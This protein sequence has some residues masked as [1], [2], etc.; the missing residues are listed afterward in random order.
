M[1]YRNLASVELPPSYFIEPTHDEIRPKIDLFL[2]KSKAQDEA[3]EREEFWNEIKKE[4]AF[5]ALSY[6]LEIK[7]RE[8]REARAT[9]KAI[10]IKEAKEA[11]EAKEREE[12]WNKIK[13]EATRL[14]LIDKTRETKETKETR[15][16][17]EAREAKEREEFWNNIKTEAASYASIMEERDNAYKEKSRELFNRIHELSKK[18]PYDYTTKAGYKRKSKHYKSKHYKSKHKRYKNTNRNTNRKKNTQF[19]RTIRR[20]NKKTKNM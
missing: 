5:L 2:T 12:F 8:E 10:E 20:L 16:A 3:E 11:K 19:R 13:R 1:S 9:R 15:E 18:K 7:A 4:A 17:R 6:E 14:A